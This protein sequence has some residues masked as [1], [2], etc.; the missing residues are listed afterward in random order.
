MTQYD[1]VVTQWAFVGPMFLF[2]RK[3]GLHTMTDAPP[4][5][6]DLLLAQSDWIRS[7]ARTLVR[8]AH[9]A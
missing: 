9:E 8:D 2:H 6:L 4:P 3:L 5:T 1:M 7:L